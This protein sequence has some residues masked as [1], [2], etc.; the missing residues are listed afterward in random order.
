VTT[1]MSDAQYDTLALCIRRADGD[2]DALALRYA[3]MRT[4][5]TLI[6]MSKP[7][8][9][10]VTLNYGPREDERPGRQICSGTVTNAGRTAYRDESARRAATAEYDAAVARGLEI[11]AQASAARLLAE[12]TAARE[13]AEAK[14]AAVRAGA[15]RVSVA[16]PATTGR[17]E[18]LALAL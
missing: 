6:A 2:T 18:Q 8:R 1:K 11:G 3:D 14:L 13:V 9:R 16:T 12:A 17:C 15:D 4:V 7:G 5:R 10:W